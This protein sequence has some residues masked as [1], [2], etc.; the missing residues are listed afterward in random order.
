MSRR[1]GVTLLLVLTS[2]ALAAALLVPLALASGTRALMANYEG[3]TLRHRLA[4]DSFVAVLP[5]WLERDRELIRQLDR[6]NRVV[7]QAMIGE[8]AI[9]AVLQDDSAKLPLLRLFADRAQE[10]AA[11]PNLSHLATRLG[12]PSPPPLPIRRAPGCLED[13]LGPTDDHRLFG[14]TGS[15][16]WAWYVTTLGQTVN[17]S[18]ADV[19][20]L[21]TLL[22]DI[23][24]GLGDD[25]ARARG[26]SYERIEDLLAMLEL[27]ETLRRRVHERLSL[28]CERYSLLVRTTLAGNSRQRYLVCTATEPAE[29][30][31]DWE[32]AP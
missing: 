3:D 22:Q 24:P 7:L 25:V 10:S 30:L 23:R 1:R 29:V 5:E 9:E 14:T 19:A 32:V 8:V 6:A 18:R 27:P 12:L 11:P 15:S 26:R 21:E 20:V 28:R 31:I 4:G 16:G 17:V 13:L 2:L